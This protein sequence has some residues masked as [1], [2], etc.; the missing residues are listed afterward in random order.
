MKR[1][2][3]KKEVLVYS[4][5]R[6]FIERQDNSM[7]ELRDI[8][9]EQLNRVV[10]GESNNFEVGATV[11]IAH[12]IINSVDKEI[13]YNRFASDN[14]EEVKLPKFSLVEYRD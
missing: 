6:K 1:N 5:K 8:L 12:E 4:E 3:E 11:A 13:Q 9:F 7:D 10:N 14:F 2:V